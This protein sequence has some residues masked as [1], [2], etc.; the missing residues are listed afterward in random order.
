MDLYQKE[1]G[2]DAPYCF[3]VTASPLN[4]ALEKL[5]VL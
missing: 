5:E 4:T 3:Y 1:Q 2:A